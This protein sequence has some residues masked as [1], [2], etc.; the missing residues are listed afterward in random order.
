MRMVEFYGL[1]KKCVLKHNNLSIPLVE[2][3]LILFAAL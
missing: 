2:D 3:C 1:N